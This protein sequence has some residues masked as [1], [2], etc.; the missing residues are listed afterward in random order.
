VDGLAILFRRPL[1]RPTG[2]LTGVAAGVGTGFAGAFG[3]TLAGDFAGDLTAAFAAA[4]SPDSP[5]LKAGKPKGAE[6]EDEDARAARN[7]DR[8]VGMGSGNREPRSSSRKV[9]R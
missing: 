4:A 1:G 6:S 7:C 9:A 5:S 2:R 3:A 8:K